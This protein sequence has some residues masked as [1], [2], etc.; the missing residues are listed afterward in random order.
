MKKELYRYYTNEYKKVK[1]L[2]TTKISIKSHTYKLNS[3]TFKTH[4][5][6]VVKE[7]KGIRHGWGSSGNRR[8]ASM[9]LSI[10]YQYCKQTKTE[11]YVLMLYH[12]RIFKNKDTL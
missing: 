6:K 7:K 12:E 8:E 2:K 9:N 11:D 10:F 1:E 4:A 5:K 3:V